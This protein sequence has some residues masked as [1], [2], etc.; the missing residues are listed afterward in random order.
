MNCRLR[1][2]AKLIG[3]RCRHLSLGLVQLLAL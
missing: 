3:A 2:A 1:L